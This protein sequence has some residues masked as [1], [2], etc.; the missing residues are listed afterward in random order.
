MG[1]L[2]SALFVLIAFQLPSCFGSKTPPIPPAPPTPPPVYN[3]LLIKYLDHMEETVL[4]HNLDQMMQ[5]IDAEYVK[6]QH[7]KNL[8][9]RTQQF[10]DE[11]FCGK[12]VKNG[13]YLCI[14]FLDINQIKLTAIV[15]IDNGYKVFY[16]VGSESKTIAIDWWITEHYVNG[17]A[18]YGIYGALG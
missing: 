10:I 1:L 13:D 4:A 17:K 18:T 14:P 9:G 7:D 5:L 6:E 16:D 8:E 12:E 15:S 2:K 11:L 3:T